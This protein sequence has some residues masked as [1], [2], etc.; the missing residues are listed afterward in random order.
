[1]GEAGGKKGGKERGCSN[2]ILI[3]MHRQPS[4]GRNWLI[5]HTENSFIHDFS[6]KECC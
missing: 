6:F 5:L 1:M 4:G 2:Y 3:L